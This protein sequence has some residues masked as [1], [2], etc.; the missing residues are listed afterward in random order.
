MVTFV[1]PM[2]SGAIHREVPMYPFDD[3]FQLAAETASIQLFSVPLPR[4]LCFPCLCVF[5]SVGNHH[6]RRRRVKHNDTRT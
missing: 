3:A 4:T 6:H 5:E 2:S 1:V